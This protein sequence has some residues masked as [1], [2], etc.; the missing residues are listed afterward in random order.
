MSWLT[1]FESWLAQGSPQAPVAAFATA[2]AA[3]DYSTATAPAASTWRAQSV[4]RNIALRI[5]AMRRARAAIRTP[6]TFGLTA[7]ENGSQLDEL[8]PRC[9]WLR[10]PERARTRFNTLAL[11]LDDGLWFDKAV[12]KATNRVDGT[13]AYVER[14]HPQR[15]TPTYRHD[16]PD[17]VESWRIDGHD[18]S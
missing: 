11:L 15:W 6:A 1:R 16:D 9:A 3:P 10:Q 8:D 14:I 2:V 5:P 18:Y 4:A 12:V 13:T 17:T 7:W